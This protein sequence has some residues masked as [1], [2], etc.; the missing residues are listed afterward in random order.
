MP[1]A[2]DPVSTPILRIG[3]A[4]WNYPHW[5]SLVYPRPQPRGFHPL[6]FL[7]D[8]FDTVEISESFHQFVRPELARLW[9]AKI[10]HN[11]Q[12]Q[13]TA[14]LNRQFTHERILNQ[15]DIKHWSEGIAPLQDAGRLG[16]VLMQ[17]PSSFRFTAENK[18][19]L[20]RVRRAFHWFPLVAELRHKS[21]TAP[22][23]S[24][25]L[26]DYHVGYC[27]LDQPSTITAAPPSSLLTWRTGYVKFHGRKAGPWHD[28][29][30]DRT[31][32]VSGNDYSYS[33]AELNEW[34]ARIDKIL[35]FSQSMFLI[36]NND[37]GGKSVV[38]ALQMQGVMRHVAHRAP[39]PA[40][41]APLFEPVRPAPGG[42]RRAA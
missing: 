1:S 41:P 10:D 42:S 38:N 19:F 29:F 15:D 24:G 3:P 26:I 37:M 7:A 34:K 6:E 17:F 22:E 8:R 36:F 33:L 30:D 13:F 20:I 18:D 21:W 25:T 4:G 9:A 39:Q 11:P 16:C 31:M 40:A 23:A 28:Q 12:F 35:P 27:N 14:R 5:D 2:K 32:K